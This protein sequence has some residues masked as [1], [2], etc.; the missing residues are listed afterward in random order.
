MLNS[1]WKYGCRMFSQAEKLYS[2]IRVE[3]LL[4]LTK[5]TKRPN[6]MLKLPQCDHKIDSNIHH[7]INLI[8]YFIKQKYQTTECFKMLFSWF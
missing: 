3:S 8:T 4:H 6:L 5:A 1:F 2:C 7:L